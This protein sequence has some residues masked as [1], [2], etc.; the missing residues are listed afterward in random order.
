MD[1]NITSTLKMNNGVEI[2]RFGLGTWQSASGDEAQNAVRWALE[3]GY[4]HIDTA[5][6]YGN[7]QDVGAG[8][9]A[10]GV[11]RSEIF[12]VTKVLERRPGLRQY[13]A[14]IRSL[15]QKTA[16][17]LFRFIS[18]PLAGQ[19]TAPG[20]LESADPPR[21]GETL[22]RGRRQQFHHPPPA[23]NCSPAPRSCPPPTRSN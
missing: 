19:G 17:R 1:L 16:H 9:A 4:R 3:A 14:R 13:P 20:H 22:P 15:G 6:V 18:H 5:A 7:E 11:P 2:P 23:R 21:R 10:S 12:L 8:I